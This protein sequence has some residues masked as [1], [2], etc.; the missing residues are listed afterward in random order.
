MILRESGLMGLLGV[1]LAIP[2]V[3]GTARYLESALYGV[4][5]N[6]PAVWAAAAALLFAVALLAGFAPAWRAA[7]IDPNTAL[8]DQ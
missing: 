2:C 4:K 6:D 7:R 5:P 8:R 3:I 1:A